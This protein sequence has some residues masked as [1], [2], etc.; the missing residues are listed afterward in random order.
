MST[1]KFPLYTKPF[2][3]KIINNS[4]LMVQ[5]R[6]KTV[7]LEMLYNTSNLNPTYLKVGFEPTTSWL[8]AMC[9]TTTPLLSQAPQ[10][11][12]NWYLSC[13]VTLLREAGFEVFVMQ[14]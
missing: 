2:K 6:H 11:M 12:Q 5:A 8:Q 7:K 10:F 13:N 1:Q 3:N 4:P 14:T 9:A